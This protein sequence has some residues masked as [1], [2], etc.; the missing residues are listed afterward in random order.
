MS[1]LAEYVSRNP[2]KVR[3]LRKWLTDRPVLL[4]EL[5]DGYRAGVPVTKLHSYL[6]DEH[7]VSISY[8]RLYIML[9][10]LAKGEGARSGAE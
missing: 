6:V 2:P 8:S 9:P 1:T 10:D 3:G 7:G 5:I 4:R